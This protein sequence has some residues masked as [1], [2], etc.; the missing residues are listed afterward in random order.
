MHA[1]RQISCDCQEGASNSPIASA[2]IPVILIMLECLP[3][4]VTEFPRSDSRRVVVDTLHSTERIAYI[5]H[6]H[7]VR[8]VNDKLRSRKRSRRNGLGRCLRLH[9]AELPVAPPALPL[10]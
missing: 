4:G 6:A 1:S 7:R 3:Q 9:L 8:V 10:C 5:H 2:T